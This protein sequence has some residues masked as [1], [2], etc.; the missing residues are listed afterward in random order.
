MIE[1]GR[2]NEQEMAAEQERATARAQVH[3]QEMATELANELA[4]VIE[5]AHVAEH[6]PG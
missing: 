2:V 1:P 4:Q 6:R 3:E 5:L